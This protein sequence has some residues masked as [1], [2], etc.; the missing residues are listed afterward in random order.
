MTGASTPNSAAAAGAQRTNSNR[1]RCREKKTG[2]TERCNIPGPLCCTAELSLT[3]SPGTASLGRALQQPLGV[4]D[5]AGVLALADRA[6]VVE[7][8]DLEDEELA[9]VALVGRD[10][11]HAHADRRRGGV[12]HVERHADR[13]LA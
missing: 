2:E 4:D 7:G 9:V 13:Q 6:G 8:L 5:R 3:F 1:S 10:G 11:P 12:L